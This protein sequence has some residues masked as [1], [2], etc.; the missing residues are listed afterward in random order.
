LEKSIRN[1]VAEVTD[2]K[3]LDKISRKKHQI[4]HA[5]HISKEAKLVKLGDK[6]YNLRDLLHGPH[7]PS[8]DV[9]RIQGYFVWAKMVA[10]GLRGTNAALEKILDDIFTTGRFEYHGTKYPTIPEGNLDEFLQKYYD[11]LRGKSD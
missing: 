11:S 1:I 7:P 4:E 2:D 5:P 3:S 10:E 6:I 8:W 9:V